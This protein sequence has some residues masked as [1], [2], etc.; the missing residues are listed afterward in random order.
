MANA[1]LSQRLFAHKKRSIRL[2]RLA[3]ADA[4]VVSFPKSGRTWLRYFLASYAAELSDGPI[5]MQMVGDDEFNDKRRLQGLPLIHFTHDYFDYFQDVPSV[6]PVVL[7]GDTYDSKPTL[8]LL[9]DPRDVVVS[10]FHHKSAREQVFSGN[11]TDFVRSVNYGIECQSQFVLSLVARLA[12]RANVMLLSYER[13]LDSPSE[14]LRSVGFLGFEFHRAAAEQAQ[15]AASFTAMQQ[16]ERSAEQGNPLAVSGWDGRT[17][18]LK[19]RQGRV[20]GWREEFSSE[21]IAEIS[22]LPRTQELIATLS[23]LSD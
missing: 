12:H 10:Y 11:I 8:L 22:R 14:Q 9:R 6:E 5:V 4:V 21:L 1:H 20:G 15:Q 3:A 7:D 2:Q 13:M 19:V 18:A 16:V 23:S 17:E